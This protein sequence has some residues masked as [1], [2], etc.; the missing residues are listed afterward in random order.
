MYEYEFHDMKFTIPSLKL[1]QIKD[2]RHMGE[3][4]FLDEKCNRG[5]TSVTIVCEI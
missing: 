1:D 4:R 3:I 2:E 5:S